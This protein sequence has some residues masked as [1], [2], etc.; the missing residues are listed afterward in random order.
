MHFFIFHLGKKLK[1]PE[2]ADYDYSYDQGDQEDEELPRQHLHRN[3]GDLRD[4]DRNRERESRLNPHLMRKDTQDVYNM[5][6]ND[7]VV[8]QPAGKLMKMEHLIFKKK[9][10]KLIDLKRPP[11][12][13]AI[14]KI[15]FWGSFIRY[16]QVKFSGSIFFH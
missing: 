11:F 2:K 10:R 3:P 4:L 15:S 5:R 14:I 7:V 16:I 1:L 13:N 9:R 8:Q 12:N 6:S